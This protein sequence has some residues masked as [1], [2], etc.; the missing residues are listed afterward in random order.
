M[1]SRAK[2]DH[3]NQ[4]TDLWCE[5]FGD[6]REAVAKYLEFLLDYFIVYEEN[7]EVCGMLSVLPVTA[8]EKSG[9]Y[10]YAVATKKAHRGN[11]L[12]T[13]L[14]DYVKTCGKYE[15][16]VLVPQSDELFDF[17]KKAG[18]VP[19]SATERCTVCATD[20][21]GRGI[22]CTPISAAEYF[23]RRRDFFKDKR[24]IEWQ[25]AV[26]EFAKAMYGGEFYS[27]KRNGNDVGIAFCFKDKDTLFI[28]E[29][30]ADAAERVCTEMAEYFSAKQALADCINF[31]SKPS[32]MVFPKTDEK[33]YFGIA[34]D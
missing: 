26:L 6:R 30:C 25:E 22:E 24:L 17:Y 1:I 2:A 20:G 12:C 19:F 32:A 7:G 33:L 21:T 28:K 18:F 23:L 34:L 16:F 10:I 14:L 15:F 31:S 8:G 5:A 13:R 9:G 3:K 27:L 11:G 29:L 4:I